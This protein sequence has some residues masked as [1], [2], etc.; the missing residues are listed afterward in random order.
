MTVTGLGAGKGFVAGWAGLAAGPLF[1]LGAGWVG[2]VA[3][4][5][6]LA[7]GPLFGRGAGW[8]GLAAGPLFGRGAGLAAGAS[9]PPGPSQG[10]LCRPRGCAARFSVKRKAAA[11]AMLA[12]VCF[13]MFL[14]PFL[15]DVGLAFFFCWAPVFFRSSPTNMK[16]FCFFPQKM[17]KSCEKRCFY[18]SR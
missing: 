9:F 7:A 13:F 3:G 8:A 16:Q 5:A 15:F 11:T 12:S 4:W 2:L 17:E 1:G 18:W 14:S 10:S 6:G